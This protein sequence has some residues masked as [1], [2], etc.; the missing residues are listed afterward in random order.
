VVGDTLY[1]APGRE[2]AG[3][4]LLPPLDRNFLHAARVAFA[5]PRT[6][7]PIDVRA[8]LPSELVNYLGALRGAMKADPAVIDAALLEFL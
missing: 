3:S 5:H 4:Q 2:R 7:R 1:G 8:P 6:G